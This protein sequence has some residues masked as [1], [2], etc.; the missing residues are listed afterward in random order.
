MKESIFRKE[1]LEKINS[2]GQLNR[3][4]RV[5][6]PGVWLLMGAIVALLLG[7]IAWGIFGTIETT[8]PASVASTVDSYVCSVNA[9]YGVQPGMTVRAGG[10]EGSIVAEIS[11]QEA[12]SLPTDTPMP[13]NDLAFFRAE[14]ASLPEGIYEAEVV[15][16]RI[17][18]ISFVIQ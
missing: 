17:T 9:S 15:V 12:M 11:M 18:P 7:A 6:D 4:I 3:Y 16:E 13:E 1:S 5:A 14:F 8:A 2:P 10:E